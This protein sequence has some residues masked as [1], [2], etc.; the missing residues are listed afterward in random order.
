MYKRIKNGM[1]EPALNTARNFM[2]I[3]PSVQSIIGVFIF[4]KIYRV[5]LAPESLL[6]TMVCNADMCFQM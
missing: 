5:Y 2:P 6:K 1:K 4:I 3:M